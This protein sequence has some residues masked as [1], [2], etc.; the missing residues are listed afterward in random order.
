[1]VIKAA[2]TVAGM[3]ADAMPSMTARTAA[4]AR[5]AHLIVDDRPTIFAD[6]LAYPLL[7]DEAAD[8]VGYHRS[9]GGHPIL[10]GARSVA[11]ARARCT[12]DRLAAAIGAGV[13]PVSYTHLTLPTICSV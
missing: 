12:E 5:A 1:M 7:G 10:A 13:T 2:G 4:A 11:A 9:H 8:L 3:V 6:T